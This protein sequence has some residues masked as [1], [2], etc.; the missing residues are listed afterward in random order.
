M[1]LNTRRLLS[2]LPVLFSLVLLQPQALQAQQTLGGITGTVVDPSGSAIPGVAVRATSEDTKLERTAQSNAQGTYALNDLPIG[3]YTVTF[4]LQGFSTE[5]V[6]GILVQA[7]RTVSLPGQLAVGTVTDSVEVDVNPLLNAVDTTNGYVLDKSQIEAIPLPTGSFTGVAILTPGVNAELPGGTGV[8]A[9]LGNAPIWA[10]GERDTSN[11][12]LM[13]GVDASNL[14]NGKSTSQVASGRVVSSTGKGNGG[15]G[16]VIQSSSSVYLSI[17]NALPSPAPETIQEVRV[18]ASMYDA[19]QGATSGAHI[20]LSTSSGTNDYHGNLYLHRG[21]NWINAAPFFFKQ[22]DAV[23]ASD[24]VPQLHRYVLGGTVGGPIIK[25]KLFGFVAYQHLHVSDAEIGDSFLDVPVGLTDDR[26]PQT[27]AALTTAETPQ[28]RTPE[29]STRSRLPC[30]IRL[31]S[32]ASLASGSY[33]MRRTST[34]GPT[35]S[36]NA[37]IPGAAYFTGD[38]AV[39]N[40]DYN[41]TSKDTVALKYYYQHDPTIAPYA[42]SNVPG[43]T[44]HLD[45]GAQVFSINNTYL[46]KSNLSTQETLGYLREKIYSTNVQAFGP[47]NIPG[48]AYP[49]ASIDTFG[50]T[51]FPGV[52]IVDVLGDSKVAGI[53]DS[54]N[55]G[56]NATS[57]GSNT[58]VFQNR[59]QPSGNAIWTKG[60]HTVSGGGSYSFTQLN[61]RDRRTDTGSV[62]TANLNQFMQGL[63]TTNNDFNVTTFLQGDANRYFR[64]NQLGLYLED[65][66]QLKPNLTFT[67][68]IRYDWDGG[69]TEK[70]GRIFNFDPSL[71]SYISPTGSLPVGEAPGTL[72]PNQ[73]GFIIAGNN[74]NGTAGVSNTTLT[75]RQWGIAPRLG[76]AWEPSMIQQQSRRS[77]RYGHLLRPW[78]AL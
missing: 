75:G 12:F 30:S 56:P 74:K 3:K 17:G 69:L 5:R 78:R 59:L 77:C 32:K 44:Q 15:A 28:I 51:Y 7:D 26:S 29:A 39:A 37:F 11:S 73:S 20:D 47:S 1:Y 4:T 13:N 45:A 65:K 68:G 34:L 16:G 27:L 66:F 67:A 38:Q 48:G 71:Y 41:A 63:V 8:N 58:G 6:P 43:F 57:Q 21:T 55:I 19:Q 49:S 70:Y 18:N 36:F 54:L 50:S 31:R 22:D 10:N 46:V 76:A 24:K 60:K 42:F 35:H 2:L 64:A 25:D 52:S 33:R 23:P 61:T 62:A 72:G 53:G 40:L 14:F 9:G